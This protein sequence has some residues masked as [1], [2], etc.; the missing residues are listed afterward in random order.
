MIPDAESSVHS[1]SL[2]PDEKPVV[3]DPTAGAV[4]SDIKGGL[5]LD[6]SPAT[7]MKIL[8]VWSTLSPYPLLR[9]SRGILKA[10]SNQ[11]PR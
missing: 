3:V 5:A 7:L 4:A 6:K 10:V 8:K 11:N 1:F 2:F 9:I